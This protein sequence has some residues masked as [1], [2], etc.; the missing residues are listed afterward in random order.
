M[1]NRV[2]ERREGYAKDLRKRF[3][4]VMLIGMGLGFFGGMGFGV[5]VILIIQKFFS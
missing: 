4:Y 1:E 2:G 5:I 3:E